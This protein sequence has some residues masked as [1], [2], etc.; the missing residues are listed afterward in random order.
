MIKLLALALI[1][2]HGSVARVVDGDT[3]YV[4]T[5]TGVTNVRILGVDT[6]ET[7]DPRKPV[8]CYGPQASAFLK[9]YLPVGAKVTLTTEPTTG[10]VTDR[11]GRTIAYVYSVAHRRDIGTIEIKR[12]YARVYAFDNRHFLKRPT[13]ERLQTIAQTKK[14]GRWGAC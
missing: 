13:Y 11:Y 14:V 6:P 12:G 2:I 9:S 1:V 10:D 5:A 3:V 4:K 7:V 8:Q